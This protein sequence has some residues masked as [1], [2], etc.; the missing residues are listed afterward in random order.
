MYG[1]K[2]QKG[3]EVDISSKKKSRVGRM[4]KDLD[5]S[6]VTTIPF[7]RRKT[8]GALARALDVS[9]TTLYTRF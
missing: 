9:K 3:E 5:L 6:R 4:R 8:L 7:N 2:L 1:N